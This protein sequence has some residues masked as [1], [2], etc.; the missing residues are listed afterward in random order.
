MTDVLLD[1]TR[2]APC[3]RTG[4]RTPWHWSVGCALD[5]RGPGLVRARGKAVHTCTLAT[6]CSWPAKL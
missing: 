2:A 3:V 1:R 4:A 6:A 5:C